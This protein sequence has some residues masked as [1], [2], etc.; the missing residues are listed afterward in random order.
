MSYYKAIKS[1]VASVLLLQSKNQFIY[2]E[3]PYY[4]IPARQQSSLDEADYQHDLHQFL[5]KW[6][7][8]LRIINYPQ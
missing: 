1:E 6:F 8:E 4:I 2:L 3:R 5:D 7:K